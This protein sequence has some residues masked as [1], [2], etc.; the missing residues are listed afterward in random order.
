ML[1]GMPLLLLAS[2][3][4]L[5]GCARLPPPDALRA[6]DECHLRMDG[7][8]DGVRWILHGPPATVAVGGTDLAAIYR[9]SLGAAQ[10]VPRPRARSSMVRASGS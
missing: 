4:R 9:G 7:G 3:S 5:T 6:T 10:R 8:A 2:I 1:L